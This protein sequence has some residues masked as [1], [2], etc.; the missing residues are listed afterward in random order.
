MT[1]AAMNPEVDAYIRR[2][3]KWPEETTELRPVLLSCGLVV[4]SSSAR[5]LRGSSVMSISCH[6]RLAFLIFARFLSAKCR[7]LCFECSWKLPDNRRDISDWDSPRSFAGAALV[8]HRRPDSG[9]T[10]CFD[11][12]SSRPLRTGLADDD[13]HIAPQRRQKAQEPLHGVLPEVPSQ[14]ARHIGLRQPE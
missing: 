10:L 12:E 6:S 2:S 7:S 14:Q 3:E 11:A 13:I 8:S 5:L 9:L 4:A 1:G